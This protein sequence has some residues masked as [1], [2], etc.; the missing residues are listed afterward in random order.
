MPASVTVPCA[1][2]SNPSTAKQSI[3][4]F[5]NRALAACSGFWLPKDEIPVEL[6]QFTLRACHAI[7]NGRSVAMRPELAGRRRT[8]EGPPNCY[9]VGGGLASREPVMLA[10]RR[11]NESD[12]QGMVETTSGVYGGLQKLSWFAE[13]GHMID[14]GRSRRPAGP[15]PV[16]RHPDAGENTQAGQ[17]LRPEGGEDEYGGPGKAL[18]VTCLW[19]I[20]ENPILGEPR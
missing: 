14:G 12:L 4:A 13:S 10:V 2:A 8:G 17:C 15:L 11:G 16:F 3:A 19:A 7:H 5:W 9:G 6:M 20:C 18:I 1:E